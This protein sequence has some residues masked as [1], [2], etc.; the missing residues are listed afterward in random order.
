MNKPNRAHTLKLN[1]QAD[2][3]QDLIYAIRQLF[4][5]FREEGL[6]SGVSGSSSVG[7]IAEY[8]HDPEMT[9]DKYFELLE[10]SA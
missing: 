10:R 1:L 4:I 6:R 9:H 8:I 2:T 3:E 7:Y 5:D